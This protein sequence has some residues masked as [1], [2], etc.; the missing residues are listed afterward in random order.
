MSGSEKLS[1]LL[2][3]N[4]WGPGSSHEACKKFLQLLKPKQI[5]SVWSESGTD[6][7]AVIRLGNLTKDW[8]HK[9]GDRQHMG[10]F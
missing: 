5:R 4:L 3:G 6:V 1:Q 7:S 8:N 2:G 10:S 9:F